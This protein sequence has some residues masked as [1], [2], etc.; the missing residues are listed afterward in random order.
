MQWR[1][2]T[3]RVIP[4]L[5]PDNKKEEER[6]SSSLMIAAAPACRGVIVSFA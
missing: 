3:L 1:E 6:G 2:M 4:T 5:R